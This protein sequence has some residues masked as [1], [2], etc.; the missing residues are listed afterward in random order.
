[1]AQENR[2]LEDVRFSWDLAQSGNVGIL[3]SFDVHALVAVLQ[4]YWFSVNATP[5][6]KVYWMHELV[7]AGG[8][9]AAAALV[10]AA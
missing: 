4:V 10:S 9:E 8:V 5:G 1:M 6:L 3:L 7:K 2:P